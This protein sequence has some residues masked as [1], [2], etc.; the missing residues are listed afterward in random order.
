MEYCCKNR[1]TD[2]WNR[3]GSLGKSSLYKNLTSDE[4]LTNSWDK[5]FFSEQCQEKTLGK[6]IG[7]NLKYIVYQNKLGMD[8]KGT[9]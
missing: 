6:G 9:M 8:A 5:L 3:K 7:L 4:I 1:C 2:K